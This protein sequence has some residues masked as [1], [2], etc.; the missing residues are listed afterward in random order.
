MVYDCMTGRAMKGNIMHE[1]GS[2]GLIACCVCALY[3]CIG[4]NAKSNIISDC[5][6]NSRAT[7]NLTKNFAAVIKVPLWIGINSPGTLIR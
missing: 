3:M 6:P 1:G 5:H 2:I 7:C 4:L